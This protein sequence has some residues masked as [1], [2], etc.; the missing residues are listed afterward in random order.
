MTLDIFSEMQ[1]YAAGNNF[2]EVDD[3]IPVF[4]C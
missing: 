3:K 1:K 4:L 2:V